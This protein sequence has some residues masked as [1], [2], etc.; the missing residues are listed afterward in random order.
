[1]TGNSNNTASENA[2]NLINLFPHSES[3]APM[4]LYFHLSGETFLHGVKNMFSIEKAEMFISKM[5]LEDLKTMKQ[6]ISREIKGRTKETRRQQFLGLK[7]DL[8]AMGINV[9]RF[10]DRSN[11]VRFIIDSDWSVETYRSH[12]DEDKDYYV[13]IHQ[14]LTRKYSNI[15]EYLSCI[16][17]RPFYI[18]KG[19]ELRAWQ[20]TDRSKAHKRHVKA[21]I[22]IGSNRDDTVYI[23]KEGLTENEALELEAKLIFM[24][25]IKNIPIDT[26]FKGYAA[27][28]KKNQNGSLINKQYEPIPTAL[29][30]KDIRNN[31]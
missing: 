21:N 10:K 18:G 13:Y 9:G 23:F 25:G 1:L 29:I 22:E 11:I 20:F 30:L 27:W 26:I 19:K 3:V 12:S 8:Q 2:L 6:A 4:P 16:E 24:F 28:G 14:D 17:Y 7:M 5:G 31:V 15:S